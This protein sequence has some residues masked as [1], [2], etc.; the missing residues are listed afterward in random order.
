ESMT[1]AQGQFDAGSMSG[2]DYQPSVYPSPMAGQPFAPVTG[3]RLDRIKV[4]RDGVVTG[5]KLAVKAER[6][7]I[8][9]IVVDDAGTRVADVHIEAI[10]RGKP[11]IDLPSIMSTGDGTFAIQNLA[12]GVYNLHA[13]GSVGSEGDVLNVAAGT[14]N[15]TVKLIRPGAIEG[16]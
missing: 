8:R 13:H 4:P 2:G 3:D 11:G 1:D 6:L 10:G 12:P 14:D 16:T 15:V 9:G 5:I 7:A